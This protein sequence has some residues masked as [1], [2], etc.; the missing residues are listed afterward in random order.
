MRFG[1]LS[2]FFALAFFVVIAF[3][4]LAPGCGRTSLEPETLGEGGISSNCGPSNCPTGCCDSNGVCRTGADTRACGTAGGRCNDCVANGFTL[5]TDTRVCGRDDPACSSATCPGCCSFSGGTR[6]CLAGIDGAA[7]GRSGQACTNCAAQ[8]RACDVSTRQCSAGKCDATNCN[9]CCVGDKCLTGT[10]LLSCGTNG[11]Q[12]V[13]CGAGQTCQPQGGGGGQ[14]SGTASCGP[15]NCGG[16]CRNGQCLAGTDSTACGKGGATCSTCGANQQCVPN[17]QPNERTCQN[18]PACGP[19]NCAGCC[20]GNQCVLNVTPA[21]CGA[22]GAAC[23][24]CNPG[25]TCNSGVCQPAGACNPGNCAGCCIGDICA[26]GTQ[27]TACGTNGKQCDNCSGK[28]PPQ[29]C[30]GGQCEQ[31]V[32]GPGNCL[33]CCV[34]NTCVVG[35]QDNACGQPNGSA[36]T[37]CTSSNQV[38][39]GRQCVDKCGPA[40]CSGC[41]ASNNQCVSGINNSACGS[42]GT[43]CANCTLQNSFCNGLVTPRRCNNQQTTCPAPYTT[44]PNGITTPVTPTL[45]KLCSEGN[46]NDLATGCATSPDSPSCTAAFQVLAAT[47]AACATCV[48]PFNKPFGEGTGLW[49]C[50]APQLQQTQPACLRATGCASDCQDDSCTQCLPTVE[51][52]CHDL[53]NGPG[54]QCRTFALAAACANAALGA[55]QLCSQ[56]S[57]PSFGQWL[58][59]VGDHFCGDGP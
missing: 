12:C 56:F 30:Q 4:F 17:G 50:A 41:C 42:G 25:E 59:A 14:C 34:G 15:Q 58:R 55:G 54:G 29:V 32:C 22:N 40:N 3:V 21:R 57:Y 16:C 43:T 23:K 24:A 28:A 51:D 9:G 31:P 18:L 13:S 45:Q 5:C 2:R 53:V 6:R 33:G 36:C 26:V 11:A 35:T 39:Q 8:G 46:L 10:D 37:D 38:C 1:Q 27:N 20:V 52:Q 47:N 48:S 19:Q 7:C 49:L 44:C